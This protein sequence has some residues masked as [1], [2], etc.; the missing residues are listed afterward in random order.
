[1]KVRVIW[2]GSALVEI[3]GEPAPRE[4]T[5]GIACIV[6]QRAKNSWV[7]TEVASGRA[8]GKGRTAVEAIANARARIRRARQVLGDDAV[9]AA[10][11]NAALEWRDRVGEAPQPIVTP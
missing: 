1:M 10:L 2:M 5:D 8:A 3:L 9:E 7:V 11:R 4:E 6:D